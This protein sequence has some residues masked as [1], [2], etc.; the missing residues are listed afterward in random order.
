[1]AKYKFHIDKPLPDKHR[2][3]D[4]KDFD[5]LYGRY[6]TATRFSFWQRLPRSPQ[7]F[8]SVVMVFAIAYLIFLSVQQEEK[9][10]Q[11]F[12]QPPVPTPFPLQSQQLA[13]EAFLPLADGLVFQSTNAQ[14]L[15]FQNLPGYSEWFL[16]GL[17]LAFDSAGRSWLLRPLRTVELRSPDRGEVSGSLFFDPNF[18]KQAEW[19]YLDESARRWQRLAA[20]QDSSENQ[21]LSLVGPGLYCLGRLTSFPAGGRELRFLDDREKNLSRR[22]GKADRQVFAVYPDDGVLLP[23]KYQGNGR[24]LLPRLSGWPLAIWSIDAEGHLWW[25][26][27]EALQGLLDPEETTCAM[28]KQG[29]GDGSWQQMN[30]FLKNSLP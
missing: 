8:A 10:K 16:R 13:S 15:A 19:Y 5:R 25:A 4:H 2:V 27:G 29:V 3:S 1:M 22:L 9:A 6:E 30:T 14:R 7:L 20:E 12:L 24:H 17:P 21:R 26:D 23:L 28:Q 18:T 11:A